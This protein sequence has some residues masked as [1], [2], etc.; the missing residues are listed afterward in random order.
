MD[1]ALDNL[2]F[3]VCKTVS[4]SVLWPPTRTCLHVC[5]GVYSHGVSH[6]LQRGFIVLRTLLMNSGREVHSMSLNVGKEKV[7]C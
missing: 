3:K 6:G 4:S 2:R 7:F 1:R 5:V